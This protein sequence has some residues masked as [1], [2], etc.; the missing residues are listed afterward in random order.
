MKKLKLFS[1]P[2]YIRTHALPRLA[3]DRVMAEMV[4][5]GMTF[6]GASLTQEALVNASWELLE[7][8]G[9]DWCEAKLAPILRRMEQYGPDQTRRDAAPR[10]AG[11]KEEPSGSIEAGANHLQ[12]LR[13]GRQVKAGGEDHPVVAKHDRPARKK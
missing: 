5:R 4:S 1:K 12:P 6:G 3:L 9:P 11:A 8:M 10:E 2:A 7:E 13:R